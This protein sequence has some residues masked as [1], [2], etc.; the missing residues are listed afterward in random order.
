MG[1]VNNMFTSAILKKVFPPEKLEATVTN[2]IKSVY[3]T[4]IV[5]TM[6]GSSG[7]NEAL[8]SRADIIVP[9]AVKAA[10]IIYAI[11]VAGFLIRFLIV[12]SNDRL[13]M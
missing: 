5:K 1:E 12:F 7:L 4:Y 3:P 2:R 9:E 10:M 13:R 8:L 6:S 11:R